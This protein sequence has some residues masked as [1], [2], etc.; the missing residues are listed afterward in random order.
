VNAI[1]R[2]LGK[3]AL[4]FR[5][6]RFRSDL[7]EE[8]AFHRAQAEKDFMAR[9]MSEEEARYAA[10][11]QFGNATLL[12]EL[13]QEQIGFSAEA[14]MQDIRFSL[15]QLRKNP[16]FAVTAILILALG[17]AASVAI[18]AFVDA[19]LIKPLPYSDPS[20]LAVLYESIPLGAKFH[21]SYLDYLD[22][23]RENKVFSAVDVY[24]QQ[25]LNEKTSEGLRQV[26]GARVTSG[27]FRTL[28]VKPMLGRDFFDGEEN[29]SAQRTM[30]LSYGAW[31]NSYGGDPHVLGRT[32]ELD[33][34]AYT[35]VG[36]LP[37]AF[38]FAPAEP[39]EFWV[40]EN[41]AKGCE[42]NRGC[43]NLY[44]IARL[45]PGVSFSTALADVRTIAQKLEKQYPN[46]NRD[47]GGFLMPLND[48]VVGD[49][50]PI[51]VA[52]LSGAGLLLLIAGINVASLILVRSESRKREMAVRGALG[53]SPRRLI[54]Q[55]ATE[56]MV[57]AIIGCALGTLGAQ[58]G[59]QMLARL[60]PKEMLASMPYL[61]GLGVN[62]HVVGFAI[63]LAFL[64]GALFAVLP[65]GR[66]R[67]TE[68]RAGLSEGGRGSAGVAWR[69]FGSNLVVLELATAMVLLVGAGLLGKSF[70]RLLHADIGLEPDHLATLQVS[71]SQSS[72]N[73]DAKDV[74]LAR[75]V[76]R[77]V[78]SLPGLVSVGLT[79]KLPIE[80]GDETTKFRVVG[81]P[82]HGEYNEVA[83]RDV[84]A[85]Y[86]VTLK[87]RLLA[88]RYFSDDED[89]S[90]PGVVVIN[91][92]MARQYFGGM[93]AVGMQ[94]RTGDKDP[95]MLIVGVISDL[96]EGQLD[97]APRGAMYMPFNQH[98]MSQ[99]ALIV[100]S[101]QRV[102]DLLPSLE[103]SVHQVD[104]G[105]AI[106]D[107]QTMEQKIHDAPSTYLHRSSAWLVGGFAGIALLL[108]VVGLYGVIAYSVSQRTREIGVRMALGAA[109]GSVYRLVLREAGAL[110]AIGIAAGL[111][112]SIVGAVL[113]R[114]L[115]FGVAAWDV[116]TL[117]GVA[118][119]LASSAL[120]ASYLPAHRAASVSP[121]D[122]LR[123]E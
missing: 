40:T 34:V 88:G 15:R 70:Y 53:A 5:R 61:N 10:K 55:Y 81:R 97:A 30:L 11:R 57:L 28:G 87:S 102:E 84:S 59:M 27:F 14:V 82:Y 98:P 50:R 77:Q 25:S 99:F 111:A 67:F 93:N 62:A 43:H 60:I 38:S 24:Q 121:A 79:S 21:L 80:D 109:R 52:L 31:K 115:L 94:I 7:D 22:W 122:A 51:L 69:R 35:I 23:K 120:L 86:L 83:F 90:K 66:M 42:K 68:I 108:G 104:R 116:P 41:P 113:M 106:F 76:T 12:H 100:R 54:L 13:S 20:R 92:T 110:I 33:D 36:I 91:Q 8:M 49:I 56:G 18:Y 3:L 96:Q 73:T 16:G 45:R 105:L 58:Q 71:G 9:G 85:D 47:E 117:A 114:K 64:S 39:A 37:R 46:S 103:K 19:A 112:A 75:E 119:L 118:M 48:V 72:Y 17:I 63:F 89:K 1:S 6:K 26:I 32:V 123:T 107:P 65:L 74:A 2:S 95:P 4:I 78:R 29:P 44:G 101:T